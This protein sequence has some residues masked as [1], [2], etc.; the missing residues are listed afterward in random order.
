MFGRGEDE[1]GHELANM[2]VRDEAK[3]EPR[4]TESLDVGSF[5]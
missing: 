2:I 3:R 1:S 4:W 5:G